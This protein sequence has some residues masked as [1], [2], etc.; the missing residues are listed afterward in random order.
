MRR[1]EGDGKA[2]LGRSLLSRDAPIVPEDGPCNAAGL[3][4]PRKI[5]GLAVL[6]RAKKRGESTLLPIPVYLPER[7]ASVSAMSLSERVAVLSSWCG[8]HCLH[9]RER[10]PTERLVPVKGMPGLSVCLPG[11]RHASWFLSVGWARC[12]VSRCCRCR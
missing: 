7:Q 5:K 6:T 3:P 12:R 10:R 11:R 2:N 9:A 4:S 8:R 1:E